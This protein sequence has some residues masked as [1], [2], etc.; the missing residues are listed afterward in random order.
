MGGLP[1][2]QNRAFP[3][4]I[5][6]GPCAGP[7]LLSV[8]TPVGEER[9]REE[10]FISEKTRRRGNRGWSGFGWEG[11]PLPRVGPVALFYQVHLGQQVEQ[12]HLNTLAPVSI[13]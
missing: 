3:R 10:A 8:E 5:S 7:P 4:A 12:T 6:P 9:S 11:G 2:L 1:A 13:T